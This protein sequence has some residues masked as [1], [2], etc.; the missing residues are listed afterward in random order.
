MNEQKILDQVSLEMDTCKNMNELLAELVRDRPLLLM[1]IFK[2]AM[3]RKINGMPLCPDFI[4]G[5]CLGL[6]IQK[7]ESIAQL[8][9]MTKKT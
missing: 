4:E 1:K 8:E 7:Y 6:L 3:L 2:V 9:E 5:L